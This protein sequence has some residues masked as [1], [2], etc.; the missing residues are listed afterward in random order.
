[1]NFTNLLLELLIPRQCP[2]CHKQLL[3]GEG[4]VCLECQAKLP[5]CKCEK[6]GNEA[7]D[8]M[9]GRVPYEHG[10][11]F[12][13]YR[14]GGDFASL[15]TRAKYGSRPW[16]NQWLAEIFATELSPYGWPFDIN[17]IIPTPRHYL[18][19]I[20][21]GYNQT[22]AIAKGLSNAWGL[23][24][25]NKNLYKKYYTHSQVSRSGLQR[26]KAV[27]G[28]FAVRHPEELRGKHVLIVDDIITTGATLDACAQ[29]LSAAGVRISFLSLGLSV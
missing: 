12:C 11:S 23:P 9:F 25:D 20:F 14:S 13:Y 17:M 16:I 21:R 6:P 15:I 3:E 1:M 4:G 18:R 24:I 28:T 19:L 5:R 26:L 10:T 7:E 2:I 27:E 8:R 29:V 22:Y